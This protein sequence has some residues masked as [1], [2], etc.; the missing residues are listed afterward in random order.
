MLAFYIFF[1]IIN[2]T[3]NL[4]FINISLGEQFF[5]YFLLIFNIRTKFGLA[6]K[7]F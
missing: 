5:I 1:V 7:F 2:S 3:Y 4:I 6:L